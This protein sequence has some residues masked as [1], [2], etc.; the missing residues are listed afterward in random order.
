MSQK[1]HWET[2]YETKANDAVSWYEPSPTTS[3]ALLTEAGLT[4]DSAVVDIGG[5]A[6][7]LAGALVAMGIQRVNGR[8]PIRVSAGDRAGA[9]WPAGFARDLA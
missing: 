3:L 1:T 9:S 5:G 6:S 2:V 4:G 8:R 7:G